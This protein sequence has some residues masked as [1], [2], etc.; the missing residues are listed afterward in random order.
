SFLVSG[1]GDEG[2]SRAV[3]RASSCTAGAPEAAPL[4]V[5]LWAPPAS[6][7]PR[8]PRR[9][10]TDRLLDD[11]AVTTAGGAGSVSAAGCVD[12]STCA[13]TGAST[14]AGTGASTS[15]SR[16][17]ASRS[18]DGKT[19]VGS[20][21]AALRASTAFFDVEAVLARL[22]GFLTQAFRGGLLRLLVFAR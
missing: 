22:A 20:G 3:D 18:L 7:S 2:R 10:G 1:S 5:C 12:S 8:G 16:S 11:G 9:S 21:T 15:G 13:S 6:R 14:C 17:G 4:T 19:A